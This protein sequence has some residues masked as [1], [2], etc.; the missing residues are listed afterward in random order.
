MGLQKR[1]MVS[2]VM[3]TRGRTLLCNQAIKYFKNQTYSRRELIIIDDYNEPSISDIEPDEEVK[4]IRLSQKATLG[5]MLNIG[6]EASKGE[7]VQKLDDDDYYAPGFL[8]AMMDGLC[9]ASGDSHIACVDSFLVLL[10]VTGKVVHSGRGW[11]AGGTLCFRRSVWRNTP[12]RNA[13]RAV[14]WWFLKDACGE[15]VKVTGPELYMLVR[16]HLGHTW[17]SIG[18]VGVDT[19]FGR[20]DTYSKTLEQIV[21]S[22]VAEFYKTL[23]TGS[24]DSRP[25]ITS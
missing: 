23:G 4:Y 11:C 9:R 12:F 7:F 5:E 18:S 22:T 6:I 16:H 3:A 13:Q 17:G 1:G 20:K 21:G 2:C 19:Y 24:E 10:L 8:A 14:D 15:S 25:E